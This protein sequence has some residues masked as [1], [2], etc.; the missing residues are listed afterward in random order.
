[1]DLY[2]QKFK[3]MGKI[4]IEDI[5][6]SIFSTK[7]YSE[8]SDYL[9][10]SLRKWMP[11]LSGGLAINMNSN[12]NIELNSKTNNEMI[13]IKTN[14]MKN[15]KDYIEGRNTNKEEFLDEYNKSNKVLEKEYK[16]FSIDEKSLE[17]INKIDIQN[18]IN[19]RVENAKIIYDKLRK[20][21]KVRFLVEDYNE[22]DALLFVP[23]V[24]E[25][26]LRNELKKYLIDNKV[27]LPV[28]WPLEES[29]NN[30]FDKELSL[31]CDQR[32]SKEQISN[33]IDL[34]ICFLGEK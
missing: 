13:K 4:I 22:K 12:F 33:Y 29:L 3:S 1:M 28:H 6:H 30:I 2:I 14:A 34:I 25:H 26:N 15:K 18:I 10:A 20:N 21:S 17:I 16:N 19:T 5:T 27:Y 32:Y 24:L 31:V 9:I 11:I 23:I 8:K 7:R